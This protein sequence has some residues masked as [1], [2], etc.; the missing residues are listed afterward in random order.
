[1][2]GVLDRMKLRNDYDLAIN[3]SMIDT[4][5]L[6]CGSLFFSSLASPIPIGSI[7]MSLSPLISQ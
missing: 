7:L 1:M 2:R 5:T 3:T 4:S 6:S